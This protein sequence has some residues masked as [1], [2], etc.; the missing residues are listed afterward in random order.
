MLEVNVNQ[1][2]P[3]SPC[4]GKMQVRVGFQWV[5]DVCVWVGEMGLGTCSSGASKSLTWMQP[6]PTCLQPPTLQRPNPDRHWEPEPGGLHSWQCRE[7]L[8]ANEEHALS[9]PINCSLIT[10]N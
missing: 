2:A 10:P 8:L 4:N 9:N 6:L 7:P 3:W 5:T 1:R